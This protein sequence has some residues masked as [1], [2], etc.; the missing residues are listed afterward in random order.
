M[1]DLNEIR[2]HPDKFDLGLKKR[3]LAPASQNLLAYDQRRRAAQTEY[4]Q[5]L[6]RRNE[7]SRQIGAAKSRGDDVS[8]IM[9]EMAGL[10]EKLP[11]LEEK[12]QHEAAALEKILEIL[13]NIPDESVPVGSDE[14]G[15]QEIRRFGTPRA[16]A[17]PQD[18][19][20]IGEGLGKMDFAAAARMSGARFVVLRQDLAR[21]E[22]AL[23]NFMLDTHTR[24]FG[25]VEHVLP[26]MVRDQAMYG[27]GQLPKFAEDLFHTDNGFYLIPTA[28][29]SL[30]NLVADQILS[31]KELPL[32]LTAWTP[33]FRSEAGAAGR[34]TRGMIRQHQFSKVELV[35]I[36]HPDQSQAEHERMT[37]AAETILQRLE[38]PYRTL[39]LCTGDMGFSSQKTYDIEVWLPA[40]NTYREISSCSNCGDFQARRMKARFRDEASGSNRFVHTLNGSGLAVGRTLIA[41]LENYQQSDGSVA[42]PEILRPYMGGATKIEKA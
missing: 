23:A 28:E 4:E 17:H 13:P 19:V 24:E 1:H 38:L 9:T 42:I 25:Y 36:T 41:V 18:H 29:V 10:K 2:A 26:L 11:Q 22:R 8:A 32:R 5:G 6:A 31:E 16:I 35:S 20:A 21:L 33:C 27:T 40:Q 12:S 3:G 15:N 30:T 7:I 14:T 39:L 37:A 34:D